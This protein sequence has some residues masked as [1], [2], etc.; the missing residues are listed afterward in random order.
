VG[1]AT[2]VALI[3]EILE[4][5]CTVLIVAETAVA[6]VHADEEVE[7]WGDVLPDAHTLQVYGD[8]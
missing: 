6:V 2:S 4:L 3:P 7:A 8:V 1:F 5:N